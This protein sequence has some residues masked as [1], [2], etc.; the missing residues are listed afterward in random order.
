MPAVATLCRNRE[1]QPAPQGLCLV[2][3]LGLILG[4]TQGCARSEALKRGEVGSAS[5]EENLPFHADSVQTSTSDVAP[6]AGAPDPKQSASVPFMALSQ[7]RILAAGTLL[8]VQL[9]E[10]LSTA[11]AQ[12]G[13]QFSA[14]V[15]TPLTADRDILVKSGTA[16]TGRIESEQS[17]AGH[18]GQVQGAGYFRLTLSSITIEGRQVAVQ[19][20]SLFARGTVQPM[21]I[22]VQ[23]GHRLTFRLTAPVTLDEAHITANTPE[24]PIPSS[25]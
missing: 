10:S 15:T 9:Q 19:T 17:L 7:P 16:V 12:A 3:I 8:T 11:K 23:K 5:K 18:P 22:G 6:T 13:D 21:G 20:S 4:L 24:S 2:L 1:Q 25:Q 14:V